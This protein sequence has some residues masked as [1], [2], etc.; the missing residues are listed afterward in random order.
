MK[1]KTRKYL[2][3][4]FD[5]A[6]AIGAIYTGYLMVYTEYGVF[7]QYPEEWVG[8]LPF[9]NWIIPGILAIIIFG[10]GNMI[11]SV[12]C[13]LEKFMRYWVASA[14]MGGVLLLTM[15]FLSIILKEYYLATL[16]LI[17]LA[18]L[19]LLLSIVTACKVKEPKLS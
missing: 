7:D 10:I 14:V 2:L 16:E 19:Q 5:L 3:G 13:F 11:A 12:L 18:M 4:I 8:V 15:L 9:H 17:L 1:S 6:F